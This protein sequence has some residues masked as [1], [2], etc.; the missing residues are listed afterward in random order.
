MSA[1]SIRETEKITQLPKYEDVWTERAMDEESSKNICNGYVDEERIKIIWE[2]EIGEWNK[3][4][5]K[6]YK[7]FQTFDLIREKTDFWD[8]Y[9]AELFEHIIDLQ[10][11]LRE[12]QH[13]AKCRQKINVI[14]FHLTNFAYTD[15]R[16]QED[17]RRE[18]WEAL[19]KKD[20][21]DHM[22]FV[23]NVP[24]DLVVTMSS[25]MFVRWRD[26]DRMAP[27]HES[28]RSVK[29]LRYIL[30]HWRKNVRQYSV[31][32]GTY[33]IDIFMK[34]ASSV[35]HFMPFIVSRI[36][37]DEWEKLNTH[38]KFRSAIMMD[39][40]NIIATSATTDNDL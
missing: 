20:D 19:I 34:F 8:H 35:D 10:T 26:H 40:V 32:L 37:N 27:D 17:A 33:N 5:E 16:M 21:V 14:R 6:L 15:T 1:E 28:S 39:S 13:H 23:D 12:R 31:L 7:T 22:D 29:A 4:V 3:R 2:N 36:Y 30:E 25:D 38:E 24:L 18:K 9:M 11:A